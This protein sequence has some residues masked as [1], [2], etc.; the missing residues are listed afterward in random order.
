MH[1]VH[2]TFLGYFVFIA[3]CIYVFEEL[4]DFCFNAEISYVWPSFRKI[5]EIFHEK[6][7]ES[8]RNFPWKRSGKSLE[9]FI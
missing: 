9:F 5:T 1:T 7:Q 4:L 6:G 2:V 8:H 3:V